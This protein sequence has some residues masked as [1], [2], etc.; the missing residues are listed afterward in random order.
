M[1][2]YSRRTRIDAPLETVWSF[3]ST[4]DGLEAVT[5]GWFNLRI[6][7]VTGTP[8]S[9]PRGE[10]VEDAEVSL[11]IRPF[12]VGPRQRWTS[13]IVARDR[14]DRE[15]WF[16][17]EMI[18]GPF[19]RWSHTHRF[20]ERGRSTDVI[21]R[22]EYELPGPFRTVSVAAWPAFWMIFRGRHRRTRRRLEP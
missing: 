8:D 20:R 6:E 18:E 7:A 12:G 14:S 15:A 5:P 13:R 19:R 16:R 2:V 17:D 22:V 10:L 4:V 11:S 3:H 9:A 1:A 21:D